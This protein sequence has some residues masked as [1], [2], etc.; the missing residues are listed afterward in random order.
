MRTMTNAKITRSTSAALAPW[1]IHTASAAKRGLLILLVV[2]ATGCGG[3]G[4]TG[5]GETTPTAPESRAT[6]YVAP[7]ATTALSLAAADGYAILAG[8]TI[9]NVGPSQ[10]SGDVGSNHSADPSLQLTCAQVQGTIYAVDATAP[11]H[12]ELA[13]TSLGRSSPKPIWPAPTKTLKLA[14]RPRSR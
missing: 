1:L 14:I 11:W 12:V 8:A 10:I 5:S 7:N 13:A 3:G 2:A 6:T 9:T 4:D